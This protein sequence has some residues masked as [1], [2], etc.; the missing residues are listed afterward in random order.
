MPQVG[1]IEIIEITP[2]I[3]RQLVEALCRNPGSVDNPEYD[4]PSALAVNP[5]GKKLLY[6]HLSRYS[7]QI[8]IFARTLHVHDDCDWKKCRGFA[9]KNGLDQWCDEI[10]EFYRA[11]ENSNDIQST[12]HT[13]EPIRYIR[14][15]THMLEP[16]MTFH[17]L[18]DSEVPVVR[19]RHQQP[20]KQFSMPYRKTY[21]RNGHR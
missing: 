17:T 13:L 8:M 12:T 6:L 5:E 21:R 3:V 4:H 2:E 7:G 15:T 16:A 9:L 18:S 20:P 1:F 19:R 14:P 11:C 10:F